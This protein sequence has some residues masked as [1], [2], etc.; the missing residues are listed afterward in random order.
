MVLVTPRGLNN[1]N[2]SLVFSN[3]DEYGPASSVCDHLTGARFLRTYKQVVCSFIQPRPCKKRNLRI[4][5]DFH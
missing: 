5:P 4:K 2:F 3:K 1:L